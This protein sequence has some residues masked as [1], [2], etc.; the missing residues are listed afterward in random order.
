VRAVLDGESNEVLVNGHV[1]DLAIVQLDFEN[2]LA[3]AGASIRQ[4]IPIDGGGKFHIDN[5]VD[6]VQVFVSSLDLKHV[7]ADSNRQLISIRPT[8]TYF[9]SSVHV[10]AHSVSKVGIVQQY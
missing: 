3:T 6:P 1:K 7:I 8:T 10:H 5:A 2:A 9:G 4:L